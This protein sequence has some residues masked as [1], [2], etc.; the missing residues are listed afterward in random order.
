MKAMNPANPHKKRKMINTTPAV[1]SPAVI[2]SFTKAGLL[3][4]LN[5]LYIFI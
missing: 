1:F 5:I 2:P 3:D 4:G